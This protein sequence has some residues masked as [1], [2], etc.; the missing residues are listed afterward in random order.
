LY[1][2]VAAQQYV[3]TAVPSFR[4]RQRQFREDAILE[5][6][7]QL[8]AQKGFVAMTMDDVAQR[9]GIAKGS[10]YQHFKSKE[11]LLAAVLISFMDR[12]SIFIENLPTKQTAIDRLK[13]TYRRALELRFQQGF[14]DLFN[15]KSSVKDV[16]IKNPAY[17]TSSDRMWEALER[18][19]DDAKR[20]GSL[21]REIPTDV[22][23]HTAIARVRDPE[24]DSLIDNGRISTEALSEH[25]VQMFFGGIVA[26]RDATKK[27]HSAKPRK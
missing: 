5:A 16:L 12:I 11:E 8:L 21:T 22:L 10:L 1:T 13:Q 18:L 7:H 20:E 3:N 15:A 24:L 23:V 9:V 25:L 17:M 14:P 6:T 27:H 4:D 2:E 26:P 19:F